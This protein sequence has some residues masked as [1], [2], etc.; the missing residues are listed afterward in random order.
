MSYQIFYESDIFLMEIATA[1]AGGT[2]R[3]Y[4]PIHTQPS[5][6][7]LTWQHDM[8]SLSHRKQVNES[9]VSKFGTSKGQK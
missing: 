7:P 1:K 2:T 9:T 8:K 5:T 6:Q 3:T 4:T